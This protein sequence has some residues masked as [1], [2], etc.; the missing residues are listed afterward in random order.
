[1]TK[2]DTN[3]SIDARRI[4]IYV[5]FA[6]GIAWSGAL[7]IYVTGGLAHS[8]YAL[9]LLT[10]VYMGAPA[11]AHLL[12]RLVTREGWQ[13]TWLRP[14]LRQGWPYWLLCWFAPALFTAVGMA[15]FFALFP[16][17][18]DPSLGR[19]R[20]LIEAAAQR[21][22]TPAPKVGLWTVV[23]LQSA[24]AIVIAPL[25]NALPTFGEE[26]GWRAYLQPK[27]LPL[28]GRRAMLL[29][30]LIWGVWHWPVVAMGHNYG[31]DYPGAPWLG[32]VTTLWFTLAVGTVLGWAALRAG[33]VWPAVIGHG[34]LNGIA[35]ISVLLARGTPN[36]LLG[37]SPAGWIGAAG[38]VALAAW[39]LLSP[40]AFA[41][42]PESPDSSWRINRWP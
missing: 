28:G 9:W 38:F 13:G 4:A 41:H 29:M 11:M 12:T 17:T 20:Q 36:L 2:T 19:V 39:I 22:G 40:R 34:A 31:L 26:F 6:F 5:A 14:R 27:L 8:P 21:T 33:S 37:P 35:G 42:L 30:G 18:Y 32:L 15:L 23:L 1:M 10:I 7:A 25:L 3:P 24:Q 16:A